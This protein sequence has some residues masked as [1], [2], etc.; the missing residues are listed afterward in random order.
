MLSISLQSVAAFIKTMFEA[1]V[2]VDQ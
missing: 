1:S 2:L